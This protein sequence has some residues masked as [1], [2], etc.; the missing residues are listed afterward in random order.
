MEVWWGAGVKRA[1]CRVQ[2]VAV[3]VHLYFKLRVKAFP[4]WRAQQAQVEGVGCVG[5]GSWGLGVI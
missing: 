2:R 5:W 3:S 4:Y 1:L